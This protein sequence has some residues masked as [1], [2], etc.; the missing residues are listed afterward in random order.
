MPILDRTKKTLTVQNK[1]C[2]K[3]NNEHKTLS[4]TYKNDSK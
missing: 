2:Y 4:F 3:K 1:V